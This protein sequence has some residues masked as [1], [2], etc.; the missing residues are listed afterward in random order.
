LRVDSDTT[1]GKA[2]DRLRARGVKT[3]ILTL[4]ARGAF[5]AADGFRRIVPGFRVRAVDTTAAGDAFTACLTVSLAE[6]RPM[7]KAIGRA[8]AAGALACLV[9]GA[10][11]SM[12]TAAEVEAFLGKVDR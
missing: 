8:N 6:G 2:A 4:G 10:Q 5:V 12:P 1:A 7:P 11:P 3:V 9:V